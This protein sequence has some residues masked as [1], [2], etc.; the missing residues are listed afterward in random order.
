MTKSDYDCVH[1]FAF[2]QILVKGFNNSNKQNQNSS[3]LCKGLDK[4]KNT[5]LVKKKKY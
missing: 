2:T 3:N 5:S 4:R 1:L